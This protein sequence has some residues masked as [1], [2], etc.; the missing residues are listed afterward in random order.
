MNMLRDVTFMVA[1]GLS[2]QS[3]SLTAGTT[4]TPTASTQVTLNSTS[5]TLAG[6]TVTPT[7]STLTS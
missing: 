7:A 4:V 2:S 1:V 6:T 5:T 3:S